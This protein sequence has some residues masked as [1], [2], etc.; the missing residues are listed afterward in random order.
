MSGSPGDETVMVGRGY[1][2]AH[3]EQQRDA[4]ALSLPL[5]KRAAAAA[6]LPG[7]GAPFV[8]ADDGAAEGHNSLLPMQTVI[9]TVRQRLP[10]PAP[11]SIVHADL[12]E[13]AFNA[14]FALLG[15]S[16]ES[17]LRDAP[18]VYAFASGKT[19]YE[20]VLPA[21]QVAVGYTASTVHWMSAAPCTIPGQIWPA[22]ATG[23]A[24]APSAFSAAASRVPCSRPANTSCSATRSGHARASPATMSGK[25]S[26]GRA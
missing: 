4:I 19:M 18:E 6:P 17:Y 14:L 23:T 21:D 2:N 11:I 8:V 13:N 26:S 9:A 15:E 7:P 20:Q 22:R 5:L 10:S 1:Y 24:R 12:L 16:Q 25:R 3:S